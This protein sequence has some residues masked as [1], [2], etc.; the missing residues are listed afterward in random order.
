MNFIIFADWLSTTVELHVNYWI[1]QAISIS[2]IGVIDAR[3]FWCDVKI[4]W[5]S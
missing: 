2:K 3:I 5:Y 1:D 4:F